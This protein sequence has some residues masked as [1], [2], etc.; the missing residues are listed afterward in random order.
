MPYTAAKARVSFPD[1]CARLERHGF[2]IR[3]LSQFDLKEALDLKSKLY[4]QVVVMKNRGNLAIEV[5]GPIAP[6]L[7]G[8][9]FVL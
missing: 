3:H 4:L 7:L 5:K 6:P 2:T 1:L 8:G 9:G